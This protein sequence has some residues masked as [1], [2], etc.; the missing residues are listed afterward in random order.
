MRN[1][2]TY[3]TITALSYPFLALYNACAAVYRAAG[4]SKRGMVTSVWMN[5]INIT[6]NSLF[7]FV[8]H[9]DVA[10]VA[11]ATLIARVEMCIRDS[12]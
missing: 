7:L 3:F 2:V 10:G 6:G 9:I 5:L 1:A 12:V 8:F 4:D 11:L